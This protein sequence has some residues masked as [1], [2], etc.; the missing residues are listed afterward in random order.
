M[1]SISTTV[2]GVLLSQILPNARSAAPQLRITSCCSEARAVRPGDLFIA[3]LQDDDDG[4]EHA[5]EAVRRGAIAVVAERVL[6]L[7]VPVILVEDTREAYGRVCQALVDHPTRE[8]CTIG[9][10]GTHGKTTVTKLLTAILRAA[11]KR[12]GLINSLEASDGIG[13][14][15]SSDPFAPPELARG[16]A[17]M[18]ANGCTH[19]VLELSSRDLAQRRTAGVELDGAIVT[20][21]RRA[22][23]DLHNTVANYQRSKRRAFDLLKHRGFAVVNA[24]DPCSGKLIDAIDFPAMTIGIEADAEITASVIER[25]VSEQTFLLSA[26]EEMIP[27]RTRMIGDH[28]VRHCLH[29]AAAALVLGI[30]LE[31]IVR[32][33]ERVA[34]IAGRMERIE[35]GQPFGVFVD[36]ADSPDRLAVA[37]KTLR[38][39]T[40]GRLI[41]VASASCQTPADERPLLGRVVER[42]ATLGILTT[43][44]TGGE[45]PL[46][47]IHDLLDGYDRPARAHVMPDREQAIAFALSQAQ[48]GDCVLVAGGEE[49]TARRQARR[50]LIAADRD[51][52][53]QWLFHVQPHNEAAVI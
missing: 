41:C 38:R 44:R 43:G 37:L 46:A 13:V 48:P 1:S 7:A 11:G 42:N 35:C 34:S 25:H 45:K 17:E 3:L 39:V 28:H 30:D 49:Q 53:E 23:F 2:G 40:Q 10:T 33:L 36:A 27:V 24:D 9:V 31:T 22:H 6:P 14:L 21:L 4:H 52:A 16:L 47:M 51:I 5:I 19:A 8:L 29:A 26:G 18:Q 50:N 15:H 20:N 12:T 32:G